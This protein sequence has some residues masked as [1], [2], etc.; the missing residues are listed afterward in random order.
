M[1]RTANAVPKEIPGQVQTLQCLPDYSNPVVR[2]T[3]KLVAPY[4][5]ITQGRQVLFELFV[6]AVGKMKVAV[7]LCESHRL[8]YADPLESESVVD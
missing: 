8:E 5:V 4:L 7:P 2:S 6:G 3:S 1:D